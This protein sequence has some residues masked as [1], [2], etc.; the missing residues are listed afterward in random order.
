MVNLFIF[1]NNHVLVLCYRSKI[2]VIEVQG[3]DV[4]DNDVVFDV[5]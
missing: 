3:I 4:I 2:Y 5:S 1:E